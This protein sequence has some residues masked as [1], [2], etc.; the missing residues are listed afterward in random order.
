MIVDAAI[1]PLEIFP[2]HIFLEIY[3]DMYTRVFII[4]LNMITNDNK[5]HNIKVC[6][7]KI[8]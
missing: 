6:L 2:V 4:A 8:A 3:E 5:G 7:L 1:L